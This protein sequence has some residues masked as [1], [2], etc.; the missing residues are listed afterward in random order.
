MTVNADIQKSHEHSHTHAQKQTKVD[1]CEDRK[2][3]KLTYLPLFFANMTDSAL[4]SCRPSKN[5]RSEPLEP[6]VDPKET[7]RD[8]MRVGFEEESTELLVFAERS[9]G[10]NTSKPTGRHNVF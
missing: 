10:P 4:F 5:R 7:T 6:V 9:K 2:M 1:T 8:D 3:E